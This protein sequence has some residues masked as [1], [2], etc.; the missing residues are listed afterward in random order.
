M[1][2]AY[3]A[4]SEDLLHAAD[5]RRF[6]H[7]AKKENIIFEKFDSSK[8]FDL[9]VI[10]IAS[11]LHTIILYKKKFPNVKIIFDYCDDLLSDPF[12]KRLIRPLYESFKWKSFK[13]F[14]NFNNLVMEVLSIS[15]IIICG[16]EEQKQ[17]LLRFN[18]S[19]IVIPDFV[20]T[21]VNY[22]KDNFKL[23][24]HNK[25]NILW[26]GMSGGLRKI[27]R[28]LFRLFANFGDNILLNI[29]SDPH[30]YLI[31]DRYIKIDTK[32]YLKK[33]SKIYGIE[34]KFWSWTKNNLNKAVKC[35]DLG[36][37]L[38][39]KKD[40][41]MQNKPENKL[42]LLSS[43]SLPTLVSSTPSYKRF[44]QNAGGDEL[45]SLS[46]KFEESNIYDLCSKDSVRA[47]IGKRLYNYA[48]KEYSEEKILSKWRK[49]LT[50][51]PI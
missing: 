39:P 7:F 15:N 47:F 33:M 25:V 17:K 12:L 21:E 38:I 23:V 49:M 3:L 45:Y 4:N 1:R 19:I 42:V 24:N 43:F 37:I 44:I 27:V 10:S 46:T 31:G 20:V 35:S 28:D 36:V 18:Q 26:E 40:E 9:L 22:K 6:V 5:R 30:I 11:N 51:F 32:K 14:C 16:S 2:I 8:N 29:V 50:S 41:T 34:V 13:N 48:T